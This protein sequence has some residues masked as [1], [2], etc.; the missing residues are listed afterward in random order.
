[1]CGCGCMCGWR[2]GC[3]YEWRVSVCVGELGGC[4]GVWRCGCVG[5]EG[6]T[7]RLHSYNPTNG[8]DGDDL[9]TMT[10]M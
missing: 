2:C 6:R 1:M 8:D 9:M 7:V 10:M 4:V 3:E 5:V